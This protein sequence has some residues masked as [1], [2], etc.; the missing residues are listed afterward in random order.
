MSAQRRM[1]VSDWLCPVVEIASI[2]VWPVSEGSS[3]FPAMLGRV[4][5]GVQTG[6]A[7]LHLRMS[8]AE[9]QQLIGTLYWALEAEQVPA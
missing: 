4:T 2:S 9:V 7:T 5:V 1:V 3:D 6:C 8:S